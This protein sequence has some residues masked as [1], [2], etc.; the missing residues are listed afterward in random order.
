PCLQYQI[1]R[2]S[3]PCV[4]LISKEEY[5]RGV[6]YAMLFLEGRAG[7]VTERLV[8]R[9]EQASAELRFKL[10]AQYR[11]QLAKLRNVQSRELV[12]ASATVL[13]AIGLAAEQG[14]YCG[15]VMFFR[16]GPS[17][18]TRSH[19]PK[20]A[21]GADDDEVSRAF[22]LQYYGGREAPREI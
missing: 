3:A 18:G 6:E 7:A 2:C 15:A 12:A 20:V 11:D 19:F 5:A 10:A 4:G 14:L 9:M 21:D 1:H 22:L 8:A 13:D 16:G 17:L